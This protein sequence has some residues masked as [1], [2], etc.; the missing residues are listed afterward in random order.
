MYSWPS[1]GTV[2]KD[3]KSETHGHGGEQADEEVHVGHGGHARNGCEDDNEGGEDVAT[4]DGVDDIREDEVED[5]AAANKLVARDGGVGEQD[6]NDAEDAGGLVVASLEEVGD[7][8]L[9]E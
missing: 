1:S 8:E 9:G 7:G 5:V 3:G 4:H 6:R 2:D